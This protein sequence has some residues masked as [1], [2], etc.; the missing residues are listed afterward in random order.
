MTA[1]LPNISGPAF[2]ILGLAKLNLPGASDHPLRIL[3][4]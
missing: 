2:E 1:T 3:L 4:L